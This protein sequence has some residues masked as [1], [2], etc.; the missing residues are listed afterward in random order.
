MNP[1]N[2]PT[3]NAARKLLEPQ[4]VDTGAFPSWLSERCRDYLKRHDLHYRGLTGISA[5][6]AVVR[7]VAEDDQ[8]NGHGCWL[9]HYGVSLGGPWACC[10]KAGECFV[11]EPYGFSFRAAQIC[12]AVANALDLQWHVSSNTW[13]F[14]GRTVRITF[15]ERQV[16]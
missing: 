10:H 1:S 14:P 8:I 4:P 13:H 16:I 12:E 3:I 9:D 15:H 7:A 2:N 6:D 5:F 11:S